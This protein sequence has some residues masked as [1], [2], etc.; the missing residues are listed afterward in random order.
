LLLVVSGHHQ[1]Q[2]H[3]IATN[4]FDVSSALTL[5][6]SE[7]CATIDAVQAGILDHVYSKTEALR[8]A[9]DAAVT[10]LRVDQIIMYVSVWLHHSFRSAVSL[11]LLRFCVTRAFQGKAGWWT[12]SACHGWWRLDFFVR[13]IIRMRLFTQ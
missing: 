6:R 5:S 7:R 2:H 4:F 9:V 11:A 12:Q 10:V 13:L 8:L 3:H 1:W